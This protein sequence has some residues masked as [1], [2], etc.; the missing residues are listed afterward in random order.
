[1]VVFSSFFFRSMRTFEESVKSKKTVA[2]MIE[3]KKED[4][5]TGKGKENKSPKGNFIK[6]IFSGSN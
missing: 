1:M 3:N 4:K 5:K 6:S 2:S